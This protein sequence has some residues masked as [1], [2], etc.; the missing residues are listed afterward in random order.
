[1]PPEAWI[2]GHAA[3]MRDI[4]DINAFSVAGM[5]SDHECWTDQAVPDKLRRGVFIEL[6]HHALPEVLRVLVAAG[7]QGSVAIRAVH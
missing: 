2:E 3:G 7:Q 1:M 4:N 6:R 5:A